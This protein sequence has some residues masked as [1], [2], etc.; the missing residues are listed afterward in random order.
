[1]LKS[2]LKEILI[3]QTSNRS[4]EKLLTCIF[5]SFVAKQIPYILEHQVIEF[6]GVTCCCFLKQCGNFGTK[7]FTEKHKVGK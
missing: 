7:S 6:T 2:Q 4:Y 1:M 5:S 3:N